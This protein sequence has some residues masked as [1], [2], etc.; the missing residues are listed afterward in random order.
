MKPYHFGID[1]GPV[2]LMVESY[3]TG[4]IW[5]I[6]RRSP[7]ITAGLGQLGFTGRMAVTRHQ[8]GRL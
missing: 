5:N 1:P 3:R 7:C 8:Q 4:V 6:I 2:V